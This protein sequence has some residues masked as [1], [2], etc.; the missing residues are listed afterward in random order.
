MKLSKFVKRA[1]SE[2]CTERQRP[3]LAA[4]ILESRKHSANL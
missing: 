1:K 2:S 3:T 4:Q